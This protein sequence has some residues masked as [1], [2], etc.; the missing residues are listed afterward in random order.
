MYKA[1]FMAW[2]MIFLFIL[3]S[4]VHLMSPV[5]TLKIISEDLIFIKEIRKI[6]LFFSKIQLRFLS[7]IAINITTHKFCDK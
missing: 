6:F 7:D 4:G 2:T 5:L 1:D 3:R